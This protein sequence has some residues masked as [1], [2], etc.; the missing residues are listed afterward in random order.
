[1]WWKAEFGGEYQISMV[2]IRNRRDCCGNR[3]KGTK[4]FIGNT[5]CGTIN[6]GGQGQWYQVRCNVRGDIKLLLI[7]DEL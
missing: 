6:G 4:V 2:K 3:L 5:Q 1:M 7:F